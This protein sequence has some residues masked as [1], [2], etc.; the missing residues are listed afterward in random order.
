MSGYDAAI[1]INTYDLTSTG[2][3][4]GTLNSPSVSTGQTSLILRALTEQYDTAPTATVYPPDATLGRDRYYIAGASGEAYGHHVA[5]A[6][7]T[8]TE[9][10]STGTATWTMPN[11]SWHPSA[12][13][14]AITRA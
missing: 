1:A 12:I 13:T 5:I 14:I 9:P 2:P 10:G 11:T 7:S 4:P 3:N 6:H 8:Q